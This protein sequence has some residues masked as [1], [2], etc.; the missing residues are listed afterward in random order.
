MPEQQHRLDTRSRTSDSAWHWAT[1]YVKKLHHDT[2][3]W[4]GW[5]CQP[6][7]A[8][9]H[10]TRK[11]SSRFMPLESA[12]MDSRWT[13]IGFPP[14]RAALCLVSCRRAWRSWSRRW[15]WDW[16]QNGSPGLHRSTARISYK[17]EQTFCSPMSDGSWRTRLIS[18]FSLGLLIIGLSLAGGSCSGSW[19]SC[20]WWCQVLVLLLALK[21]TV[22]Y[23]CRIPEKPRIQF[24][25]VM[26]LGW[27][28]AVLRCLQSLK[29][30]FLPT[31]L[32]F[33][34]QGFV[35][36]PK[37]CSCCRRHPPSGSVDLWCGCG[38]W[39]GQAS[40]FCVSFFRSDTPQA[41]KGH[42]PSHCCTTERRRFM[43]QLHFHSLNPIVCIYIYI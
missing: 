21:S 35:P 34:K 11:C 1:V 10:R 23:F 13:T 8:C 17:W 38:V 42:E 18:S 4:D 37:I 32:S 15:L 7:L 24:P 12:C 14:E 26:L 6:T 43:S 30:W 19:W 40:S 28:V 20:A 31:P 9:A 22:Y 25:W 16:T 27:D 39:T 36:A 33:W 29:K 41:H 3:H 5:D 2:H